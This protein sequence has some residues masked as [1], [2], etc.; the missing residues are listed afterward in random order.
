MKHIVLFSGGHSSALV[1]LRV[2]EKYG[3][4][5]VVLL[6]HDI[7]DTVEDSDIKRFKKE[8]S[9]YLG[10]KITYANME[11]WNKLDQF[12]VCIKA[13][14]FKTINA[15]AICTSRMKTQP[16]MKW[17][18]ENY[19]SKDCI[20][21]YGFDFN[22]VNRIVRRTY[23]MALSGYK[24]EYPLAQWTETITDTNTIGIKPPLKYGSF[25]HANCTGCLKGGSQHWYVVYC[26]RP[27]IFKKAKDT[28]AIIGNAI[29]GKDKYLKDIECD[30]FKMK[31]LGIKATEH[32]PFQTFWADAKKKL[33]EPTLF[34]FENFEKSCDCGAY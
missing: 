31:Q 7:I 18:E 11:N 22:E 6:N 15:P 21:Y 28:E 17:L 2:V 19:P 25:K 30:F 5:N 14:A 23:I 20:C 13:K 27:D 29:L 33:K 16:F 4:D 8:I 26:K 3:K 9:E 1:A 10:I 24:T 32:I 12:D 34:N